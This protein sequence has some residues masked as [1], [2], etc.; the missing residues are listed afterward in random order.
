MRGR[1]GHAPSQASKWESVPF[2]S[3]LL[4]FGPIT[5]SHLC[6]CCHVASIPMCWCV[7]PNFLLKR[8]PVWDNWDFLGSSAGKDS[9]CKAGDPGSIP[10]SGRY[11]GEGIGYPLQYSWASLVAQLVKNSL[12]CGRPGFN[13]CDGKIPWRRER[14]P[15]PV[16]W[17]GEFHGPYRWWGRKESDTTE[18]LTFTFIG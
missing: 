4:A 10:V 17:S 1:L 15:T 3:F 13:P 16:F 8:M 5:C 9:A 2:P 18:W 6:F 11:S 7:C 12:Q 14:L